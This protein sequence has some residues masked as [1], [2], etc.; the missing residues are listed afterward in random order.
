MVVIADAV[1]VQAS[2][3]SLT[4]TTYKYSPLPSLIISKCLTIFLPVIEA[5]VSLNCLYSILQLARSP[6]FI[7]CYFA[8]FINFNLIYCCSV[9][10]SSSLLSIAVI[11]FSLLSSVPRVIFS[12][13]APAFLSLVICVDPFMLPSLGIPVRSSLLFRRRAIFSLYYFSLFSLII[14]FFCYYP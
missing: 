7:Y 3:S 10:L 2:K 11:S 6:F 14:H 1:V 5:L 13:Y 9:L 4:T 12:C 8:D